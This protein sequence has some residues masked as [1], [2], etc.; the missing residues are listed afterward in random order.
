MNRIIEQENCNG[1]E[2]C[3]TACPKNAITM[4]RDNN[5]FFNPIIDENIC[6]HCGICGKVCPIQN[7]VSFRQIDFNDTL[8]YGGYD[9][10]A[11]TLNKSSSGGFFGVLAEKILDENGIVYGVVFSDDYRNV[12]YSSSDENPLDK[13]RGSKYVTAHKNGIYN[14]IYE[15][16]Q[17]GRKVLF[18]GLPC[19]VAALYAILKKD[20]ENLLTCEL[21]CAGASS[22]NLLDA[23]LDWL[24]K[25]FKAK[26]ADFSFRYKKYGWVPCCIY[27]VS[28]K[29]KKYSKI[30][31][32]TI[33]GVGMK[34]AKRKA[35][36]NCKFKDMNR[37]ADFT[38]GD[39]WNINKRA[40]Y[41]NENGTSVVFTRTEKAVLYMKELT[42]FRKVQ[43]D[44]KSAQNG[45][46]QQLKYPSGVPVNRDNYLKTLKEKGGK[47]AFMLYRPK[48][49][50]KVKIK[51]NMPVWAY[52]L[53]RR[54]DVK[55]H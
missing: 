19:E 21:I 8:A 32:E 2:A 46:Y 55:T 10:N 49:D 14:K 9:L 33:F 4:R 48:Q 12:Y 20:F 45:N 18:V 15:Q 23:Q 37:M 26:T 5:G 50:I 29:G 25:K 40:D 36:F 24:Q 30:L 22:Y 47:T 38:I 28:E 7:M 6:V 35:C 3:Q 31:D 34:Y 53:L 42:A 54:L 11:K 51:N 43:V 44:S 52:K 27:W 16:L 13:M 17:I 41:Y 1:C 39:F